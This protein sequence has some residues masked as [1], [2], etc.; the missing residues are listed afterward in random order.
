MIADEV[1]IDISTLYY[2]WGE[3]SDL[4]EAVVLDINEDLRQKLIEVESMI[5]GLPLARRMDIAIDAVTDYL[6][7]HP[8]ISNLVL[9]HYFSKTRDESVLDFSVPEL[10]SDIAR[11]MGLWKDKKTVPNIVRMKVLA[12]MNPIHSFVSGENFFRSLLSVSKEEYVSMV[13]ETLKFA[14]LPAFAGHGQ[15]DKGAD[16]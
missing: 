13:K 7:E 1:G 11:S 14:L 5:H 16:K 10:V 3:K 4:Y 2:H 6:F 8:E 9:F 12:I 15:G